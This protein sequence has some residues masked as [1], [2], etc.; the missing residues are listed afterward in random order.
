MNDLDYSKVIRKV[1]ETQM[2]GRNIPTTQQTSS[3]PNR[4][5]VIDYNRLQIYCNRRRN[6]NYK[7]Y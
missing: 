1:T 2:I 4:E 3:N 7:L 6:C 5:I